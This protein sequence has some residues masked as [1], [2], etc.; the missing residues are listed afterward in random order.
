MWVLRDKLCQCNCNSCFSFL[1]QD[2][3]I[4]GVFGEAGDVVV[5]C[6]KIQCGADNALLL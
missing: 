5:I 1:F 2:S 3:H 6:A 4:M